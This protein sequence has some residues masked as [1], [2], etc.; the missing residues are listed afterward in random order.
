VDI[1]HIVDFREVID[2]RV[3]RVRLSPSKDKDYIYK[4]IDRPFY[5]PMD[6]EVIREELKALEHAQNLL[7]IVQDAGIVVS[8]NPYTTSQQ[9]AGSMVIKGILLEFYGG[10]SLQD[11]FVEHRFDKYNWQNLVI[12]IGAAVDRLHSIGRTHMDLKP[13]NVVLDLDGNAI[14]IDISG[15]GVTHSWLAPEMEHEEWPVDKP[16]SM[17]LLNDI[18]AYGK[19][20]LEIARIIESN[21]FTTLL[22]QIATELM[23]KAPVSRMSLAVAT[24]RLRQFNNMESDE[25]AAKT[26]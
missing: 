8:T 18:W 3:S 14:L 15:M 22:Q 21:A 9:N 13:S 4:T 16:F 11:I 25:P 17:R 7:N 19:L 1:S 2:N 10:G 20:L 12:Q 23:Q 5:N 6:T 24:S 26:P